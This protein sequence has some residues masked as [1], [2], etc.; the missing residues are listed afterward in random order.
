MKGIFPSICRYILI[1]SS[2]ACPTWAFVNFFFFL[3][4]LPEFMAWLSLLCGRKYWVF[5]N[6]Y[7]HLSFFL[8]P[9]IIWSNYLNLFPFIIISNF[10]F[11]LRN[12]VQYLRRFNIFLLLSVIIFVLKQ[13]INCFA[14]L[15]RFYC[16]FCYFLKHF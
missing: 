4:F 9:L 10:L 6:F 16:L 1:E 14:F 5:L 12:S 8:S 7:F 13:I 3:L 15:T 11:I 2:S